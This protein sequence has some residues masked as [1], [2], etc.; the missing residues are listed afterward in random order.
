MLH[1]ALQHPPR[2]HVVELVEEGVLQGRDGRRVLRLQGRE[3]APDGPRQGGVR[4]RRPVVFLVGPGR[5][6]PGQGVELAHQRAIA[7]RSRCHGLVEGDGRDTV[8]ARGRRRRRGLRADHLVE[9]IEPDRRHVG[10]EAV[11][12]FVAPIVPRPRRCRPE[13][14]PTHEDH[15]QHR[16]SHGLQFLSGLFV[17]LSRASSG[18]RR[19]NRRVPS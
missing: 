12:R 2:H 15:L 5:G 8:D 13:Q 7:P 14:E 3:Q 1:G 6:H 10:R 17:R 18:C 9:V 16:L 4:H 11:G 19:S